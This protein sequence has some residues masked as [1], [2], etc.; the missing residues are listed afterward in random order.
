M[1][2]VRWSRA[3]LA[4]LAALALPAQ[5]DL[6]RELI[7]QV[8]PDSR[9]QVLARLRTLGLVARGSLAEALPPGVSA[10]APR[11]PFDFDP[12]RVWK[13]EAPDSATAEE[14]LRALADDP[15]VEWVERNL[16]RELTSVAADSLFPDDPLFQAGRQWGLFADGSRVDV[17]AREA[18]RTSVGSNSLRLALADTGIDPYQPDLAAVLPDGA[19]RIELGRDVA[20]VEPPGAWIDSVGH[21]TAVAGV[22]AAR[23]NDGAHFD[24]LGVAGVCGGD[25]AANLG[26][27]LV[28]IKVTQGHLGIASSYDIA[29]AVLYATAVGARAMNL[30]IAGGGASRVERIALYYAITHGCVV[31]AAAGNRGTSAGDAPQY[32]AAYAQFGLCIQVGASDA[33]D[34]RAAFSSHGPGLDLLAPGVD[35]WTTSLTYRNAYD[36]VWPGVVLA[37]GTSLAAPFVTGAVGLLVAARPELADVDAQH[38][39]RET[40]H[41]IGAPGVDR[42]TGWGRLDIAAALAAVPPGVGIWHDEVAAQVFTPLDTDTLVIS[43]GGPGTLDRF[44]GRHRARRIEVLATVVAPDSFRSIE[45]VWP[46]V[47]GTFT[48]QGDYRVEGLVPWAEVVHHTDRSVTLRGFLYQVIDDTSGAADLDVP[49]PRDQVRFGFTLI[50]PVGR[51]AE[52]VTR[53]L[54]DRSGL[55]ASPN[56]FT[57]SVRLR[58][59]PGDAIA[60]VDVAGHTWFRASIG[61]SG[62]VTW[63]AAA[64][65]RPAPPGLYLVRGTATRGAAPVRIVRLE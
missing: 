57:R 37:A 26:C 58:G 51:P 28:P 38:L 41:D 53:S 24:S 32:P 21:G 55:T 46:R 31:V 1:R 8:A 34:Q 19:P 52:I 47:G 12:A 10:L 16:P 27:R 30:S 29:R 17:Q 62:V 5:A 4:L 9:P 23:T 35:I 50:G 36:G 49:L 42:E 63:D 3:S 56:P 18:W 2:F 40:A 60:I 7:V 43:E 48:L 6:S 14:A 65:R 15:A 11:G 22:M 13:L 20:G 45:R 54:R 64:G 33:L 25:G 61:P 59:R 44:R 39:L